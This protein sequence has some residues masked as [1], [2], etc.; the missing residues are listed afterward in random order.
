MAFYQRQTGGIWM[1]TQFCA[2]CSN[3]WGGEILWI[4]RGINMKCTRK[5]TVSLHDMIIPWR[6]LS[7]DMIS[8]W[9]N[10]HWY[11]AWMSRNSIWKGWVLDRNMHVSFYA[12]GTCTGDHSGLHFHPSHEI[13]YFMKPDNIRC[14]AVHIIRNQRV[15]YFIASWRGKQG[16]PKVL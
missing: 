13:S 2:D 10:Q 7:H 5:R 11:K 12:S 16:E 15:L 9:S 8:C 3:W 4:I 6:V 1:M 14:S